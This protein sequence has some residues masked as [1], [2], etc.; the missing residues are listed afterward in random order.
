GADLSLL[1]CETPTRHNILRSLPRQREPGA[2]YGAKYHEGLGTRLRGCET[3]TLRCRP[4]EGGDPYA[5]VKPCGTAG[6]NR[7]HGGYGSPPSRGRQRLG[8]CQKYLSTPGPRLRGDERERRN[9]MYRTIMAI[10]ALTAGLTV[11]VAA[12]QDLVLR[13]MGSFHVGGRVVEIS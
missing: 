9:R 5:A 4:R 7:S 11:A 8:S 13:G 2:K 12:E 3:M 6:D 10:A 1:R